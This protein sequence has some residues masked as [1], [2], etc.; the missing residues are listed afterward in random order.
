MSFGSNASIVRLM[1]LSLVILGFV[2]C[3]KSVATAPPPPPVVQPPPPPAP[4]ITLS[5]TP[6]TIER[7]AS[8]NLQWQSTN[9]TNVRIE[10]GLGGVNPTGTQ[11]VTPASSVTYVATATGPGG[12]ASAPAR[13]TVNVAAP[14]ETAPPPIVRSDPTMDQLFTQN[15]QTIFF[16]Y[17]KADIRPDQVSKLQSGAAWLRQNANVRFTIEGHCDERGS[18]EYNLGLGDQRGN[19]VKEYLVQQGIAATRI[20]VISYGEERPE[21]RDSSEECMQRNRR[22][23]FVLNR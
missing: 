20:N 18:Q 21:C 12:T 6:E 8:V 15:V 17:D 16:D 9:A 19:A 10:P 5:A 3:K 11:S 23:A 14:P 13:V 4:T 7:G 1:I 22:A 2:A